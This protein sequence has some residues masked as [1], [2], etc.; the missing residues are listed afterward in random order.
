M[1]IL[2]KPSDLIDVDARKQV[3]AEKM[4]SATPMLSQY[5]EIKQQN[6]DSLLFFR[7]GDFYELFFDDAIEAAR[8][9][10]I[11]LTRRGKHQDEDI[12]MCGVPFHAADVY[13]GRLIRQGFRVA[14]CEQIEDPVEARKRGSKSVVKRAVARVITPGTVTEDSLLD[15]R[16]NNYLACVTLVHE[17]LSVAWVDVSIGDLQTQHLEPD[18]LGT[19][20]ARISPT[21][22]LVPEKL[23][24][25]GEDF[26]N[27]GLQLND[28]RANLTILPNSRFDSANGIKRL[29]KLY[30]VATLDSFGSFSRSEL[31]ACGALVDY[32]ELTQQGKLP[33]LNRPVKWRLDR[34]LEIDV[35]TRTN[36]ELLRKLSGQKKGS[37]LDC[38][39][40]TQTGSGARLLANR[41]SG[42]SKEVD[43]INAR[44]DAVDYFF[45]SEQL[46]EK[47]RETLKVTPDI[48]RALSRLVV[49]R[50]GPRDLRAVCDGL[51]ASAVLS[52][53]IKNYKKD[54][55]HLPSD[56]ANNIEQLGSYAALTELLNKALAE[57]LPML[58]RDGGFIQAGYHAELDRLKALKDERRQ[59]IA[60][61]QKRYADE[62]GINSIKIKHNNVLG[63]FV[64]VTSLHAP[65]LN[66]QETFIHRQTMTNATRFTTI[67]LK[68]LERD[69]SQAVDRAL[70]IEQECFSELRGA[71]LDL[72]DNISRTAVGISE[73]DLSSSL[74]EL[75]IEKDYVRPIIN[76]TLQF[77][78][79]NGRHPVVEAEIN[80][81]A[82]F[83][84]NNCDLS[85]HQKLW[86]ITGPNMAGK[87]TFLRQN[88]LI[89]ILAHMG[90]YV[91][92]KFAEIGVVDRLFSRVGA[93]DD[94]ARGRSTFMVEM[95]ET[96]AILNLATER[97]LVILDE[98]GRGTATFDGLSIAWAAIEHLHENS[99]CRTLFATHYHELTT[100]ASRLPSLCCN[101]MKIKEWKDDIIFLHEVSKGTADRSYGIHVAKLAGLPPSVITRAKIVLE[102]LE[103]GE[104]SKVIEN[105]NEELPLFQNIDTES[106]TSLST[107]DSKLV[108]HLADINVD[109]L[110]PRQAMEVIYE[111][112][113]LTDD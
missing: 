69:L 19:V 74:A 54:L 59:L 17:T 80:D 81:G 35:A 46:R 16:S 24:R 94:L 12:P 21:E 11:T 98:I 63:Y 106:H 47:V 107:P 76:E 29:E 83:V 48:E 95:V 58:A 53:L 93:A 92:A 38:I 66:A 70:A 22:I 65:K 45:E 110:T 78:I 44:L 105:L 25:Q 103:R 50:G 111:L 61:L 42:P 89:T 56:I 101:T 64:E 1:D 96:A 31:S 97:S 8:A 71:V 90:S 79:M 30:N 23:S 49:D 27:I 108:S 113:K 104:K 62:S 85:S 84:S 60:E 57:S 67:E 102:S 5:F 88:A 75:A 51:Y 3:W 4:Q 20:L 99:G 39:D 91:P 36:L 33:R 13:L 43:T 15:S 2:E 7:M 72:V 10:D 40:K 9:L 52:K 14:I 86:L 77:N 100:L 18:Q 112:K 37:L 55:S 28:W 68:E 34:T 109:D 73:I 32:L 82:A 41:L 26:E 6:P 87:S